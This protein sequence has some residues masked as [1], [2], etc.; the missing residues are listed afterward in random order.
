MKWCMRYEHHFSQHEIY[1][2]AKF[3]I[4]TRRE[5][6]AVRIGLAGNKNR[7]R[8]TS[9]GILLGDNGN[10]FFSTKKKNP[11]QAYHQLKVKKN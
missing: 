8:L 1:E 2:A 4:F 6:Y 7:G 11:T 5:F 3:L 10:I 9:M